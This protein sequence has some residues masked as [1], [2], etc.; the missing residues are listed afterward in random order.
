[1]GYLGKLAYDIAGELNLRTDAYLAELDLDTIESLPHEPVYFTPLPKFPEVQ[2]DLALVMDKAI[3]CEQVVNLIQSCSPLIR[4]VKLFDVY[5]GA[6]I[7]P[8]KKS[9]AFTLTFRPEEKAFTP[10]ELDKLTQE[11][12]EKLKTSCDITLRV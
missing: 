5:E 11:I 1:M 7:P 9:L 3:S 4:E 6:P 2:R 8:T 10:E 12:L